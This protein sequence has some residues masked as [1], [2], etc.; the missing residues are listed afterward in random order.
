MGCN[1]DIIPT[2]F[3]FVFV[4]MISADVIHLRLCSFSGSEHSD[5]IG[6]YQMEYFTCW[7]ADIAE[8]AG[9]TNARINA[10]GGESF[11]NPV[12]AE[13]TFI[14]GTGDG[15]KE[16]RIIRAGLNAILASDALAAV[17][18]HDT[19]LFALIRGAC[20]ADI[21]ALRVTAMIA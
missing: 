2:T 14:G 6:V 4:R 3:V 19:V 5:R 20:R 8:D 10:G 9:A 16:S 21:D 17:D 18:D 7:I 11:G 1:A 13:I 15:I 12:N